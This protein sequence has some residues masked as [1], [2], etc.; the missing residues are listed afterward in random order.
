MDKCEYLKEEDGEEKLM[1]HPYEIESNLLC[2]KTI[3]E[4]CHS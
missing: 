4:L 1:S 3:R 2:I